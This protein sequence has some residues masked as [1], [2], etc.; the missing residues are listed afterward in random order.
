[1][2]MFDFL[3]VDAEEKAKAKAKAGAATPAATPARNRT[4]VFSVVLD[5][6]ESGRTASWGPDGA[7]IRGIK[8]R[9]AAGAPIG[10]TVLEGVKFVGSFT[11]KV[12]GQADDVL[13]ISFVGM[14]NA[15][16]KRLSTT[17]PIPGKGK[18]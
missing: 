14:D 3:Y 7:D 16:R 6:T 1:M 18:R 2:G 8:Q 9:F 15:L 4:P 12:A 13:S 11:G 17:T 10:G 5:N